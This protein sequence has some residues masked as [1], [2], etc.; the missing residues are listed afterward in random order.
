MRMGAWNPVILENR[1]TSAVVGRRLCHSARCGRPRRS[2]PLR[3]QAPTCSK[4]TVPE[5]LDQAC[6]VY[7]SE[8]HRISVDL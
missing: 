2:L 1:K 5:I 4:S 8:I 7:A 6:V 3:R